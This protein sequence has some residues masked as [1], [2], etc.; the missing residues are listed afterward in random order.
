MAGRLRQIGQPLFQIR[1]PEGFPESKGDLLST[2]GL[3]SSWQLLHQIPRESIPGT[4][5]SLNELAP[6]DAKDTQL[7]DALITRLLGH[8]VS[9]RTR[10]AIRDAANQPVVRRELLVG[11]ILNSPE[12][13]RQ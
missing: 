10:S 12:F 1:S 6:A 11:L 8:E 4:R 5:I 13:L 2:G 7:A 3:L 9:A